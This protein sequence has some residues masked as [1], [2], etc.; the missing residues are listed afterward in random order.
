ME[1]PHPYSWGWLNPQGVEEGGEVGVEQ[2]GVERK[3]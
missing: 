2:E 1:I 3:R